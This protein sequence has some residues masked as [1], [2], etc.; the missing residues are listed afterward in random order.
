MVH[1]REMLPQF[2]RKTLSSPRARDIAVGL[3]IFVIG[4]FKKVVIANRLAAYGS[5]V[6][7]AAEQ[8]ATIT[9]FEA[10]GAALSYTFQLYFD[11]SGYS[12]MAIGLARL[13]GIRL[14]IN[15]HSP[16]KSLN[17]IYFWRRWHMTLSRFL[18]DYL[19]FALG[20]NRK[21]PT[22]RY[23]NLMVTMILGGLWHG[24]GWTF[25]VWGALHGFYL[26]M[27]HAWQ[28]ICAGSTT[29]TTIV[30]TRIGWA[31]PWSLTFMDVVAGWV[32]FRAETLAGAGSIFEGMMGEN[33]AVL[34][35]LYEEM[36]GGLAPVMAQLN[37]SFGTAT[38]VGGVPQLVF[39]AVATLAVL[40]MPNTQQI[41][42]RYRPAILPE[43]MRQEDVMVSAGLTWRA[44]P[45]WGIFV[46]V[47]AAA[48]VA[49]LWSGVENELAYFQF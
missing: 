21:G 16:Y 4:L 43:D 5:P 41:M 48:A 6:F 28:R 42:R 13:F 49:V 29:L 35:Q 27:S 40:F 45:K 39:L 46:G 7:L 11:F 38:G 22:R 1:H 44:S 23:I 10:W 25:V 14:P 8:G 3:T 24:A 17:I 30:S 36:L 15:F 18:R 9:L 12:D 26:V 34:P 32:V 47:L 33:G 19:Y 37:I 31:T 2:M 20:G